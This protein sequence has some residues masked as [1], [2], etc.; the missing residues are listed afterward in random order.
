[1]PPAAR[2]SATQS[3]PPPPR[4]RGMSQ[5]HRAQSMHSFRNSSR[6]VAGGI[7]NPVDAEHINGHL[8]GSLVVRNM[9]ADAKL[10]PSACASE[11]SQLYCNSS[12]NNNNVY[13]R[14]FKDVEMSNIS[15]QG[16]NHPLS[17]ANF[18]HSPV[19]HDPLCIKERVKKE[20]RRRVRKKK[21][22]HRRIAGK[23][24]EITCP[25]PECGHTDYDFAPVKSKSDKSQ[26]PYVR[27]IAPTSHKLEM[28]GG[29]VSKRKGK[30]TIVSRVKEASANLKAVKEVR[31]KKKELPKPPT[32]RKPSKQ[33]PCN[34]STLPKQEGKRTVVSRVKE[35]SAKLKAVKENCAIDGK[36][37][38]L[39]T[40]KPKRRPPKQRPL[41]TSTLTIPTKR[42]MMKG[43][44]KNNLREMRGQRKNTKSL[45]T[46]MSERDRTC[47]VKF[48]HSMKHPRGRGLSLLSSGD[49]LAIPRKNSTLKLKRQGEDVPDTRIT[50]SMKIEQEKKVKVKEVPRDQ[51]DKIRECDISHLTPEMD[52]LSP[53]D[54][55]N[56]AHSHSPPI[57]RPRRDGVAYCTLNPDFSSAKKRFKIKEENRIK[58]GFP[59]SKKRL[60]ME[61]VEEIH[62]VKQE[63]I[64]SDT[65]QIESIES[66]VTPRRP[67]MLNGSPL[68]L[69]CKVMLNRID[70]D[71]ISAIN[72]RSVLSEG[73]K[74]AGDALKPDAT[75]LV[76][77]KEIAISPH[78]FYG[79]SSRMNGIKYQP[80]GLAIEEPGKLDINM[81]EIERSSGAA[82]LYM[83][84]GLVSVNLDGVGEVDG[85][86]VLGEGQD[87][88]ITPTKHIKEVHNS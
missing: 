1:M 58:P 57:L 14:Y 32:K 19:A 4:A 8:D 44:P 38:E 36:R 62:P 86:D 6:I 64:H 24:K 40:P 22:V 26:Q 70:V 3:M 31:G 37:K 69:D 35:A 30:P 51:D 52:I 48:N 28:R 15:D 81:N 63:P 23:W 27:R 41:N 39:L 61:K 55:N 60:R 9:Q 68:I 46:G 82:R 11:I 42:T 33:R 87:L 88:L 54:C 25:V 34:N 75:K 71:K 7:R 77:E 79:T 21:D 20:Q 83:G 66:E 59:Q 43:R 56:N 45:N 13:T 50:R 67:L 76:K 18:K 74:E 73:A 29:Q 49:K 85:Q 10:T 12:H 72:D 78:V 65:R 2:A 47:T 53:N 17:L 5:P 80:L 16:A 84:P